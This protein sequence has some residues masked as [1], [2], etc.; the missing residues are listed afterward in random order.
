MPTFFKEPAEKPKNDEVV[1]HRINQ[2]KHIATDGPLS[3]RALAFTGGVGMVVTSAS[4]WAGEIFT[5]SFIRALISV[6]TFLF[7]MLFCILEIHLWFPSSAIVSRFREVV[8]EYASFLR[9]LWG[10]GILQLFAGS[11]QLS[12]MNPI[13]MASGVFMCIVGLLSIIVGR[14]TARR[15]SEL[16]RAMCDQD[17][18]KERFDQF[19]LN[20]DGFISPS[21]FSALV[22]TL[23]IEL[24]KNEV[25]SVYSLIDNDQDLSISY[26]EFKNWWSK[27]QV[28]GIEESI[29]LS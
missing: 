27:F 18:V 10:R 11:L 13:D 6:Y 21:E 1:P 25:A 8:H 4:D 20:G 26:L 14:S 15:L 29:M 2:M 24:G 9:F 7:G 5:F 3:Y 28:T 23:G 17:W 19:D 22:R 16:K 12:Q